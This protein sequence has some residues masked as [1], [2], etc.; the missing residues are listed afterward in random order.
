MKP[1][2]KD[3]Q[4]TPKVANAELQLV[5]SPRNSDKIPMIRES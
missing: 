2:E 5:V 3:L 4:V 1:G